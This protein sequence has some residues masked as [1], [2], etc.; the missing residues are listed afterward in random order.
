MSKNV[1]RNNG[2][3]FYRLLTCMQVVLSISQKRNKKDKEIYTAIDFI[4]HPSNILT[5]GTCQ[6]RGDG[7]DPF[8]A[9]WTR[10]QTRNMKSHGRKTERSQK[11]NEM[12]MWQQCK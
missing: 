10:S 1:K 7:T 11:K 2:N 9:P 6:S 12:R 8:P 5:P 3:F 4:P